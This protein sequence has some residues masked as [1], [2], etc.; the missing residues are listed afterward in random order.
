MKTNYSVTRA[1]THIVAR[2]LLMVAL[3]MT[4]AGMTNAQKTNVTV[5]PTPTPTPTPVPTPYPL[6]VVGVKTPNDA[7][8]TA[9][10]N[11]VLVVKIKNLNNELKREQN[12]AADAPRMDL[13]KFV[14]F[15]QKVEITDLHPYAKDPE[16]DDLFF[17][18]SRSAKSRDAWQNFLASPTGPE[19]DVDVT[20]G[21]EGKDPLP[22]GAVFRLRVYDQSLLRWAVILFVIAIVVFLVMAKKTTIIRDSGPLTPEGGKLFRPY[23]LGRAQVAWWFFIIMGSFLFIALVT[24]D[25]DTITASSL[26]LLGIG[27]GTALGS[28]MVDSNKR[29]STNSD[30]R[31]LKPQ[32]AKLQ[33]LVQ[34]LKGK[35]APFIAKEQANPPT[36]TESERVSLAALR[37]ELAPKEAELEQVDIQVADAA[38]GLEKPVTGGFVS[39]ILSDANGITFHRFQIVVWTIV[40]GLIFIWSVWKKLSMPEFSETLLTLMGISAGTYIGFKIPERQTAPEDAPQ[41]AA[42][43]GNAPPPPPPGGNAPAANVP[44]G[45]VPAGDAGAN[46]PPAGDQLPGG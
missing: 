26:V 15:L 5:T 8:G 19:R 30:L 10:L 9:G 45:N 24:W 16:N 36:I 7:K 34:E 41:A 1:T 37:T 20:V 4:A 18:L 43:A 28:A 3:L 22:G 12:L 38:S 14:L 35:M 27:T 6:S 11:D 32:Q 2:S 17:R 33:A 23:S 42:P 13:N 39:D 40:L 44:A 46:E 25:F 21:P 31:T 29:E